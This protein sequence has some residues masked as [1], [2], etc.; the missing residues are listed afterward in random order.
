M[1]SQT[2]LRRLSVAALCGAFACVAPVRAGSSGDASY[3][4]LAERYFYEGFALD[5]VDATTTGVHAYDDSLGSYGAAAYARRLAR[6]RA[7]LAQVARIDPR[8]LSPEVA[9][10]RSMLENALRD[11][12]LINGTLAKWRHDPDRYVNLASG[13]IFSLISREYAPLDVRL[14]HAILREFQVPR[15]FAEAKANLTTVDADSALIA[16]QDALGAGDFFANSVPRAFA[17]VPDPGLQA[18]F[19]KANGVAR[20]AVLDFAAW[21]K[22]GPLRHPRGTYAIGP[23]AYR[24][25]LSYEEG[26][27]VPLDRYLQIGEQALA[28]TRAQFVATARKVDSESS[29]AATV[30]RLAQHHPAAEGLLPAAQHDLVA[31]RAFVI[32]HRIVTLPPDADIKVVETPEFERQTSFASMDAP[33]P[34]ERVATRAYFNVTPVDPH[35]S[36]KRQEEYLGFL[37]DYTRP[38][39]AAHEVYPGHYVN[40]TVDK[41]RSLSLTRRLLSSPSFVEG[42]AHYDEQM[43][44]DE[45]WGGGDPRVRLAQLGAALLRECRYVVGVKEHTQGMTVSQATEFFMRNAFVAHEPAYHEALRGTQDATYGYYTLGKLEI[46]KLR[47]DMKAKMGAAFTLQRFHDALL[48]HGDPPIPLLRPLLLGASDT[49][50]AL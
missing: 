33:G 14:R 31:L 13:A 4:A 43:V 41:H 21:L 23:K 22:A 48:A 5:P 25:R 36:A 49:G 42:W 30:Q 15:L 2:I 10:D 16:Y 50:N 29:P 34:L 9:V 28:A 6:D 17:G 11:D 44:V 12:L 1:T 3:G 32:D 35:W 37:N 27:D 18:Q 24:L 26:L 39:I 20:R 40:F 47:A 45:G 46:L 8:S 19:A 38:I 7:Y